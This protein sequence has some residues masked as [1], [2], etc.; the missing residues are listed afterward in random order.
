MSSNNG[1]STILGITAGLGSV[2]FVFDK[3]ALQIV[4]PVDFIFGADKCFPDWMDQSGG[5]I[6]VDIDGCCFDVAN[7]WV[8]VAGDSIVLDATKG[9][10]DASGDQLVLDNGKSA[11]C[12]PDWEPQSGGSIDVDFYCCTTGGGEALPIDLGAVRFTEGSVFVADAIT[13]PRISLGFYEGATFEA[14]LVRYP[15][16]LLS[17]DAVGGEYVE[18]S[19]Y[20]D[21]VLPADAAAG[22]Y[23]ELALAVFPAIDLQAVAVDGASLEAKV[24]FTTGFPQTYTQ[25]EWAVADLEITPYEGLIPVAHTGEVL[26]VSVETI[27]GFQVPVYVGESADASLASTTT[28]DAN[29]HTGENA[30]AD[31]AVAPPAYLTAELATGESFVASLALGASS[32]GV[33][34]AHEGSEAYVSLDTRP[35]ADLFWQFYAGEQGSVTLSLGANLGEVGFFE[36]VRA[37]ASLGEEPNVYA[38]HGEVMDWALRT[39][40]GFQ[41]GVSQGESASLELNVRVSE[42]L[43]ELAAADGSTVFANLGALKAIPLAV[44]F[45]NSYTVHSGIGASTFLDLDSGCA[46]GHNP[47][48]QDIHRIE[49]NDAEFPDQRFDGDRTCVSLDLSAQP[50]FSFNFFGGETFRTVDA[51]D[52]SLRTV[53]SNEGAT[54]RFALESNINFRLCPGNFIP[55]GDNVYVELDV[56]DVGNCQSD[57]AFHGVNVSAWLQANQNFQP[58]GHTGETLTFDLTTAELWTLVGQAGETFSM[59]SQP[60]P[61]PRAYEGV[62]VDATFYEPPIVGAEGA[63]A[64]ASL[65]I[66]YEVK[67]DEVGCLDNEYIWQDDN[68]DPITELFNPVAVEMDP[69]SHD[70]RAHCE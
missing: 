48:K 18:A 21:V 10:Q 68:G 7:D 62:R 5:S 37:E 17:A 47:G 61:Q 8:S 19:I 67:F 50:R 69:F 16:V 43:G 3:K 11:V 52:P 38:F 1:A 56:E 58:V 46:S 27:T 40:D 4:P 28:F 25:G 32:F 44:T 13:D 42:G 9:W 12:P 70:I 30:S 59:A 15:S 49:M 45:Y 26:Q 51:A 14:D 35:A 53:L 6:I 54:M 64:E 2:D 31:L 63:T 55:D 60:D 24:E 66:K 23:L 39:E 65:T 29:A 36:G 34:F 22:E 20:T 33:N 57:Y 41:A